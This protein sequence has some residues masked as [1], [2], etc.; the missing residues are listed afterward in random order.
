MLRI[1]APLIE[2]RFIAR[3]NRFVAT[4]EVA[5]AA[6]RVHVPTSSRMRELLFP[7]ARVLLADYRAH[8][9]RQTAYGLVMAWSGA[10]LVSVDS[11]VPNRLL[12]ALFRR[13]ALAAFAGWDLL[14]R[15]VPLGESRL[16]FLL[17]REGARCWVEAK[18]VTLVTAGTAL[19]PDAPTLRGAR[20]LGELA[21][22]RAAGDRAAVVFIVQRDDAD[23]CAPNGA[24]DPQFARALAEAVDRGVEAYAFT[25]RVTPE[26]IAIAR[27]VPVQL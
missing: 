10:T 16:D 9:N 2:G 1:S 12:A 14:R 25:C 8:A 13:Q 17:G 18:S 19:F 20:H 5:G 26:G 15:E 3:E 7:G 22:A 27:P 4:V 6:L 11:G 21:A 24:L 23:Q